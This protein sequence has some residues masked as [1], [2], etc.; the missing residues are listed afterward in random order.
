M[1]SYFSRVVAFS[2]DSK[3]L[4][5]AELW[6]RVLQR[7]EVP[8]GV[9]KPQ[10]TGHSGEP[11][12]VHFSPDGRRVATAWCYDGSIRVWDSSTGEP[13]A[14]VYRPMHGRGGAFS[15]DGRV[16]ISC[17][18]DE[19]LIFSDATSGRQLHVVTLTDPERP[20]FQQAGLY[21]AAPGDRKTVVAFSVPQPW[22]AGLPI[23]NPL[24]ITG[25]DTSTHKQLFRRRRAEANMRMAVSADL[26][27]LAVSQEVRGKRE[28]CIEDL[29]TGQQ[30][31][32]LPPVQGWSWPLAFSPDGR[33]LATSGLRLWE[34]ATGRQVLAV[35]AEELT[36]A[37]FSPD[38]RL[39]ALTAPSRPVIVYDLRRGKVVRR[40][41]GLEAE[42]TSLA[43]SP[44]GRRL[45]TGMSDSTV[46]VW[47]G[48]WLKAEKV[49]ALDAE[50]LNRAWADLG[51]D[52]GKAFAARGRLASSPGQALPFLK[53]R[54][55]PVRAAEAR[56]VRRLLDE[57][58]SDERAVRDKAQR[59]L[60]ELGDAAAGALRQAL[61]KRPA[62]EVKRRLQEL[63]KRP[64]RPLVPPAALRA[65]RA[66]AV[67]EDVGTA[68]ARRILD[69]LAGGETEATLT[70]EAKAALG[71]L[72]R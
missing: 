57:L 72:S 3:T 52:P 65:V 59:G 28:V 15:A 7:W 53:E 60:E 14:R 21:V 25:W 40:I 56:L 61:A 48:P 13:L 20:R 35:P 63:L 68:E 19:R 36:R 49:A 23:A 62:A 24:L 29:K 47:E 2:P 26:K 32:V 64:G 54:V 39:L 30:G 17:W 1:P 22:S 27:W 71:R 12:Q 67:L 50:G 38:G 44:D 46:L 11:Y 4:F 33:L 8:G 51:A 18:E 43:F 41:Q 70:R 5:A 10:P 16:L 55:R 69:A 6:S 58:D 45:L 34:L 37:A 9:R 42:A 66:V 31:L